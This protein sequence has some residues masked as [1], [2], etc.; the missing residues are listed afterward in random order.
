MTN[1]DDL[2]NSIRALFLGDLISHKEYTRLNK[3][4]SRND[5]RAQTEA[6]VSGT[7]DV[8]SSLVDSDLFSESKYWSVK[9]TAN[10]KGFTEFVETDRGTV[11]K[12]LTRLVDAGVLRKV[13]VKKTEEGVVELD[14]STVNAFQIRYTGP[15][16]SDEEE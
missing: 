14:P 7:V 10:S 12:A 1:T 5:A 3:K 2:K 9:P 11:L 4:L 16:T 13:G 6:L 15:I 8:I